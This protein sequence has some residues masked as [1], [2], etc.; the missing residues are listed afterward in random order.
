MK[1][2]EKFKVGQ[3]VKVIKKVPQWK[4]KHN[5][6]PWAGSMD[7]TIGKF[8]EIIDIDASVGYKLYTNLGVW[9]DNYWYPAESLAPAII[10]GQQ[11]LFNFMT[12]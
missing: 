9:G 11:L 6:I 8:Y 12:N 2:Y 3:K 7:G 1:W 4:Y 10:K 5:F